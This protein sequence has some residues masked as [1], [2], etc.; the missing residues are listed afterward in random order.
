MQNQQLIIEM[1]RLVSVH[2][3]T[4]IYL[5]RFMLEYL[6]PVGFYSEAKLKTKYIPFSVNVNFPIS[7]TLRHPV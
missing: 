5:I 4:C 7:L 6:S 2:F 3:C 1:V